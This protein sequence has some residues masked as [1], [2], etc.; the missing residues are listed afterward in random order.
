MRFTQLYNNARC[1]PS[2]AALLTGQHPHAVGMGNMAGGRG[3]PDFPGYAGH[4]PPATTFLPKVLRD[5]GYST[6]MAGKW[7]LGQPGPIARGFDEFYGMLHEF[8][9]FW[10]SAQ[11]A[12]L[13]AGRPVTPWRALLRH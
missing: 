8:D 1:C 10:D 7:H 3:R 5:V 2:R 9:S 12:R 4:V 11:Y 13:P 6:H